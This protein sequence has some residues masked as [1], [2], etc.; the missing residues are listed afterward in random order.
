MNYSLFLK[1]C[2]EKEVLNE[3]AYLTKLYNDVYDD[4]FDLCENAASIYIVAHKNEISQ[5]M[6]NLSPIQIGKKILGAFDQI[7]K[8]GE[9]SE[10]EQEPVSPL[11][12]IEQQAKNLLKEVKELPQEEMKVAKKRILDEICKEATKEEE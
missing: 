5:S 10:T 8:K 9:N 1:D 2:T 11:Q 7:G 12:L 4:Y 3:I 6:A